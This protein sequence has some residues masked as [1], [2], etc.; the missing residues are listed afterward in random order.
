MSIKL[1][2]Q[3]LRGFLPCQPLGQIESDNKESH[4]CCGLTGRYTDP[5]QL[6]WRNKLIEETSSWDKRDLVDTASVILQ[7]L[8]AHANMEENKGG[9]DEE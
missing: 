8:S 3:C 2:E 6:C 5:F 1:P 9:P 4:I 7:A